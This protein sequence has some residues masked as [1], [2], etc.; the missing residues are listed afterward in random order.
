MLYYV[1]DNIMKPESTWYIDTGARARF[2]ATL[3]WGAVVVG[4]TTSEPTD[5]P[6]QDDLTA[7]AGCDGSARTSA[8]RAWNAAAD[9]AR[10][11]P[12]G[13][14]ATEGELEP[15][16]R[17]LQEAVS[18]CPKFERLIGDRTYTSPNAIAIRTSG[19][20]L[21]YAR[22]L[23]AEADECTDTGPI[24]DTAYAT[25]TRAPQYASAI[26]SQRWLLPLREAL[27][28]NPVLAEL[29]GTSVHAS[30][31]GA[32]PTIEGTMGDLTEIHFVGESPGTTPPVDL[33]LRKDR[34]FVLHRMAADGVTQETYDGTWA[35]SGTAATLIARGFRESVRVIRTVS[36]VG[37][38][39][40]TASIGSVSAYA[41][42][43]EPC[44]T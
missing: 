30:G 36:Q 7:V 44:G 19:A 13:A 6:G 25:L 43:P 14:V 35:N 33:V 4:C 39:V 28:G 26:R 15:I 41:I 38:P 1:G 16:A 20:A 2:L 18:A 9:L 32:E 29:D 40:Y 8:N 27:A 42:P 23:A 37:A 10:K 24:A 12:P 31:T 17:K 21:A 3:F 11:V 22:S 34:T 5:E